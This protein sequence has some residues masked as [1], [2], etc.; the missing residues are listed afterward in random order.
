MPETRKVEG[1]E[2]FLVMVEAG[3]DLVR[4]QAFCEAAHLPRSFEAELCE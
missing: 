3:L 2:R 1:K 4:C